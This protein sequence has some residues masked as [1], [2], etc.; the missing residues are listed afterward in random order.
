LFSLFFFHTSKTHTPTHTHSHTLDILIISQQQQDNKTSIIIMPSVKELGR[1]TMAVAAMLAMS[2]RNKRKAV[3]GG[4][5]SGTT[6]A[7]VVTTTVTAMASCGSSSD[8]ESVTSTF[9]AH[10]VLPQP[11]KDTTAATN[12]AAATTATAAATTKKS[13]RF[14]D[15]DYRIHASY[16]DNTLMCQ[17]DTIHLWYTVDDLASF[18]L[19]NNELAKQMTLRRGCDR[20]IESIRAYTYQRVIQR[21][22]QACLKRPCECPGEQQQQP[23]QQQQPEN[24]NNDDSSCTSS[25]SCVLSSVESMQLQQWLFNNNN[26]NNNNHCDDYDD[27]GDLCIGLERK[28]VRCIAK[29]AHYRRKDIYKKVLEIQKQA[30]TMQSITTSSSLSSSRMQ[31]QQ[32]QQQQVDLDLAEFLRQSCQ[33][34]SR[35]SRLFAHE[36]AVIAQSGCY[37][38]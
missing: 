36:L 38:E 1:S 2:R 16:Y 27:S 10:G 17:E 14:H 8:D 35:P 20:S 37:C 32:Q 29:D 31:Q 13:V 28:T 26:N 19:E 18:K 30:K 33:A 23:T 15:E 5:S 3:G 21:V 7:V 4:G 11:N 6:V 24:G 12:T 22:Y 34:L 25:S 9:S